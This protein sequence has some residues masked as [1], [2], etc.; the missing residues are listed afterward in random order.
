MSPSQ[1]S[2]R[3]PAAAPALILAGLLVASVAWMLPVS[4]KSISR[5]LLRSAGQG[6]SSVAAF[7][8]DL[9]DSEKIGPAVFVLDVARG[10]GDPRAPA[11]A[12]ALGDLSSRQPSLV[13]WG[14]WDPSL[15]PLFNLRQK[16]ASAA[17]TPVVTFLIPERARETTL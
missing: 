1:E 10:L 5:G 13:A 17:S 4:L 11:L 8:R 6:T 15:D 9:V 12:R 14:G 7:G 2:H 3:V 16:S